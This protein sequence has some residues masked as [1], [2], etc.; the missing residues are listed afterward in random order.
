MATTDQGGVWRT[1]NGYHVFIKDGQSASEAIAEQKKLQKEAKTKETEN[2]PKEAITDKPKDPVMQYESEFK[3][4]SPVNDFDAAQAYLSDDDMTQY[5]PDELKEPISS[6]E[7]QLDDDETGRVVV[8]TNRELTEDEAQSLKD[9]IDGQNSDGLGEGFEQQEFAT[10]Y[11][12]PETGEGPFTYR[13]FEQEQERMY[14]E[15]EPYEYADYL[16]ENAIEGATENLMEEGGYDVD[17]PDAWESARQSIL[18]DPE[19]Y[20]DYDEIAYAKDEYFKEHGGSNEDEW[21]AMSS[22]RRSGDDFIETDI[23]PQIETSEPEINPTTRDVMSADT[24]MMNTNETDEVF[25]YAVDHKEE[26]IEQLKREWEDQG[27]KYDQSVKDLADKIQAIENAES[28]ADIRAALENADTAVG[29]DLIESIRNHHNQINI[30]KEG[31]ELANVI[32]NNDLSI[33]SKYGLKDKRNEFTV[34]EYENGEIDQQEFKDLMRMS[35]ENEETIHNI[36][37]ANTG[38]NSKNPKVRALF[39]ENNESKITEEEA[40]ER[41]MNGEFSKD[42]EPF[43]SDEEKS[44]RLLDEQEGASKRSISENLQFAAYQKYLKEHPGSKITFEDFKKKKNK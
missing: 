16:N 41:I 44:Q 14:D 40:R 30:P 11:W 39:G 25:Q 7:W 13:E 8:K 27:G 37:E 21:Y 5:L 34:S 23:R 4:E 28:G 24:R 12:N 26:M 3:L 29:D 42:V 32:K 15:L 2:K 1:I 33:Q 6:V 20:L 36:V 10:S 18:D 22:M 43:M 35:G 31:S 17:D 38:E 19:E 9:W